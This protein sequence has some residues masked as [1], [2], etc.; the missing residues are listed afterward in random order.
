M[1]LEG[2]DGTSLLVAAEPDSDADEVPGSLLGGLLQLLELAR[3]VRE[4]L[5]DL[6]SLS[7]D[8]NFPCIHCALHCSHETQ[9]L[10]ESKGAGTPTIVWDLNPVLC[11]H[12]PHFAYIFF[13]K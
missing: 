1:G 2:V 7:F 5:G 3:N 10:D 9:Q 13:I 12:L 8:S 11:Q 6:A 4:V